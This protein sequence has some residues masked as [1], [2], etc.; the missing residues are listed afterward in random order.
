M[1][2]L[3]RLFRRNRES[4]GRSLDQEGEAPNTELTR[5]CPHCGKEISRGATVC[6]YCER[7]LTSV[8]SAGQFVQ[9]FGSPGQESP[10]TD[11]PAGPEHNSE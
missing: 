7:E 9:L 2:R 5:S 3:G 1:S 11:S 6:L 4:G 10:T 8:M